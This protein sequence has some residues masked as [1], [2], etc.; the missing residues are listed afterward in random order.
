M[1]NPIWCSLANAEPEGLQLQGGWSQHSSASRWEYTRNA[2]ALPMRMTQRIL[3]EVAAGHAS[4]YD[5]PEEA[6][7]DVELAAWFAEPTAVFDVR[8]SDERAI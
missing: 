8:E 7:D 1:S 5:I 4:K 6:S 3:T 2:V